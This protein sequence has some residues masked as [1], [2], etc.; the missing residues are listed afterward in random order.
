[1]LLFE[2]ELL[3]TADLAVLPLDAAL[4]TWLWSKKHHLAPR[5]FEDYEDYIRHAMKGLREI[6]AERKLE[7]FD[8]LK[9]TDID[10]NLARAYQ[11]LRKSQGVSPGRIN[12]EFSPIIQ[13]RKR[14]FKPLTDYQRLPLP[15]DWEGV[16]R[17]LEADE[18][19]PFETI[20]VACADDRKAG[21]AAC[22]SLIQKFTGCG[23]G[24]LLSLKLKDVVLDP[25][26]C[27]FIVPKRGAKRA[28]R[29][30]K[31]ILIGRAEWAMRKLVARAR[32]VGSV[33]P[34]H[35]LVPRH[36]NHNHYDPTR[37]AKGYR[38][39]FNFLVSCLVNHLEGEKGKEFEPEEAKSHRFRRYDLRHHAISVGLSDPRV[40][41]AAARLQF[42]HIT[43]RMI[44]RYYHGNNT[45]LNV[46]AEALAKLP[47]ASE[48]GHS[49]I[50]RKKA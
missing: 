44:T 8:Q 16:G 32:T 20:C 18:D 28:R 19:L 48:N 50:R 31:I 38:E 41:L 21:V 12:Q 27:F 45:V 33:S 49:K 35:F 34:E 13:A 46:V 11:A 7:G 29:E 5:T 40:S 30:R 4:K 23:P 15:K 47:V 9:L 1:M 39:G 3:N 36:L 42:G 10:G 43:E 6:Y 26:E 17:A 37:P 25:I 24:E 14:M 22:C 2:E